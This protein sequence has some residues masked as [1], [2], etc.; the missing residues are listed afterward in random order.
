[1]PQKLVT[2]KNGKSGTGDW[3]HSLY[4]SVASFDEKDLH[5]RSR[6]VYNE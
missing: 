2:L 3:I 4:T 6:L 1:M 5:I